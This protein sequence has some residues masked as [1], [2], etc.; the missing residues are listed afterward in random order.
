MRDE[1]LENKIIENLNLRMAVDKM[2]NEY[3][4]ECLKRVKILKAV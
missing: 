1:I 4:E 2:I 3:E